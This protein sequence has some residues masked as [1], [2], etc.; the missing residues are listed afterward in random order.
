MNIIRETQNKLLSKKDGWFHIYFKTHI[1]VVKDKNDS[2]NAELFIKD[3]PD[4]HNYS[5]W[6]VTTDQK[7]WS[8]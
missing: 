8:Q 6:T 1:Q 3:L 2:S 5:D 4:I 7:F